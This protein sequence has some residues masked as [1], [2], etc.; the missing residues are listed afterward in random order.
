MRFV[1]GGTST[2]WPLIVSL[3]MRAGRA[4]RGRGDDP[5]ARAVNQRFE[6]PPELLDVGDVGPDGAVVKGAD[7]RAAS[8]PAGSI[9]WSV[10]SSRGGGGRTTSTRSWTWRDGAPA[11]RSAHFTT[12]PSGPTSPTSRSSGG[13]SKP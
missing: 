4:G 13:S 6:L 9:R 5:R 2:A 1:P 3:G 10:G 11:R 8:R 7:R 12:A